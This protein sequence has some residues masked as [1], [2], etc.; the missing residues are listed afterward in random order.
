MKPFFLLFTFVFSLV[1]HAQSEAQLIQEA[2]ARNINSKQE[3]ISAL[4]AEGI[5]ENQARQL[6]RMRGIDFDTFLATYLGGSTKGASEATITS[7]PVVSEIVMDSLPVKDEVVNIEVVDSLVTP[8]FGYEIFNQNPFLEKEYTLGNIDE[9][10][11]IAPGDVLRI[12]VFGNNSLELETKVDLNGNIAIPNYGV[13]QA[14]GNSFKTLKSR[15]TTYLGKYFSGLLAQPQNVFLDVS[16]TQIRPVKVT[17]LGQVESPGPQLV[18]GL[19]SVLNALYAA[20]GVKTTG[21]LREIYVY[22]NN[23]KINTI[24]VY[25]YITKGK[26]KRDIRLTSNDVVFVPNRKSTIALEGLAA[27][28][29]YFELDDG[30]TLEQLIDYSGGLLPEVDTQAINISR[31]RPFEK[32]EAS[33]QY[34]RYLTTVAYTT[35]SSNKGFVLENGDTVTLKSIPE[36]VEKTLTVTGSVER[37]GTYGLTRYSNLKSLI[38]EAAQGLLP[39]T[40]LGKVDIESEDKTGKR[41]FSTY[42][43]DAVLAGNVKVTLNEND[44][45]TVYS[46]EEVAGERLVKFSGFELSNSEE[47]NENIEKT[48]FWRENLSAFD[49]IFSSVSYDELTFQ[50]QL[51]T[52][53]VDVKRYNKEGKQFENFRLSF[54]DLAGL[55]AFKLQPNDEVFIFNRSVTE[56]I[57]PMIGVVGYVQKADTLA[58]EKNMLVEDA[59][60]KAGGFQESADMDLVVINRERFDYATGQLSERFTYSIDKAYLLGEKDAPATPFYLEDKDIISVRKRAGYL[61]RK[62]ISINGAVKFPGTLISEYELENFKSLIERVGGLKSSANLKASYVL[63]DGKPLAIDLSNVLNKAFLQDGDQVYIAENNGT[64]QTLGGI[65]NESLF[66]WEQ[67][68]R[69]KYYL[70]NSGGKIAKEGGKAYLILPNGQSKRIGFLKN[71]TVLPGSKIMV[72]RKPI[73]ERKEGKFLDDFARVF[74]VISGTLTTILLTQRL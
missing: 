30:E 43:L 64:V 28:T 58:L 68:K 50:Q 9:G 33:F 5:S 22:R 42:N 23:R 65:E 36:L 19:A 45:V 39:N 41:S 11:I 26:L 49:V 1:S 48:I 37:P 2:K 3:A 55:K 13:F 53:R 67:G 57:N 51:L 47:E 62:S 6:A 31:I 17:V 27:Q 70:R 74:G 73:K 12:M 16:L 34:N 20:G 8:Y 4:A 66:I 60:L 44:R 61:E 40:Y 63:R 46:L 72:N 56:R 38:L 25:D 35:G 69:A 24:D 71:P 21:S 32:R 14:A 18:N 54:D 15:L 52:S 59:I 29:G 10:Y 7:I